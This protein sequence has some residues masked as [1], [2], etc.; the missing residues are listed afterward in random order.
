[1][2]HSQSSKAKNMLQPSGWL[3]EVKGAEDL[4]RGLFLVLAD[5]YE[6]AMVLVGD[7]AGVTPQFLEKKRSLTAAEVSGLELGEVKEWHTES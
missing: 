2:D 3:I 6:H 7:F 1:M 5:K 4:Q